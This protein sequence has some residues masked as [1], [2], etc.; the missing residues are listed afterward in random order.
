MEGKDR[1][2]GGDD[3]EFGEKHRL[4]FAARCLT[5]HAEVAAAVEGFHA[6]ATRLGRE[7]YE[8]GLNHD[9]GT[10]DDDTKV[11]GT[12]RQQVGAHATEV[13]TDEGKKQGQ[14]DDG[15]HDDSGA[16][17]L[18]EQQYDERDEDDTLQ[19]IVHHGAHGKAD[20]VVA[21]V[22]RHYLH[23]LG[24]IVV[25]YLADLR[26]Q[27]LDNLF[28]VLA[29]AHDD[30]ALDHIAFLATSH[31]AEAWR[32]TLM[33]SGEVA[34]KDRRAPDVLHHDVANLVN[35]VN[36]SDAAHNIGLRAALDDVAANI[37]VAVGDG[38]VELQR[39]NA[40]GS[41]LVGVDTDLKGLH[42]T[43]E[44]DDV[45]DAG[46]RP[47]LALDDP[48]LQS[49]QLTY[50]PFIAAQRVAINLTR[51]TGERLNVGLHTIGEVGIVEQ[52]VNLLARELIVDM[53]VEAHG[54]HGEAEE[55]RR[56]NVGLLLH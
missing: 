22:E 54:D 10:I 49:L 42:L 9:D 2:Q 7:G 30:D 44:A 40:I 20:K 46:H 6:D 51:R 13:Q 35:V 50:R 23:V 8:E 34:H 5:Y 53:V 28:G 21:V 18:H 19:D 32:T 24:Q 12:H 4:G 3:D 48:V 45:G 11:D 43:A 17:V 26:F 39:T 55:R 25:L 36:Q 15:G 29:L 27:S 47:E 41:E 56:A 1:Q 37:D 52:V 38:L 16:P 14:G 33:H 31:L